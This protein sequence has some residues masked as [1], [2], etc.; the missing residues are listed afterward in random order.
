[1]LESFSFH[2]PVQLQVLFKN[3]RSQVRIECPREIGVSKFEHALALAVLA[4]VHR[5]KEL[6]R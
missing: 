2:F 6:K 1:V 3:A 4:H 5:S